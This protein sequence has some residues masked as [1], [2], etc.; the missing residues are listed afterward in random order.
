MAILPLESP[1]WACPQGF[2]QGQK[3]HPDYGLGTVR[4]W[5]FRLNKEE[6]RESELS[7]GI[8]L[9]LLPDRRVLDSHRHANHHSDLFSQTGSQTSLSLHCFY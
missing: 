5:S 7:Y 1:L 2:N 8:P 4:H 3:T 6:N 9:P